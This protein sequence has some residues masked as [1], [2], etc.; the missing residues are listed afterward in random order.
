MWCQ[1]VFKLQERDTGNIQICTIPP[2]GELKSNLQD[3]KIE[4][5]IKEEFHTGFRRIVDYIIGGCS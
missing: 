1:Y 5:I 4:D 3:S 2:H